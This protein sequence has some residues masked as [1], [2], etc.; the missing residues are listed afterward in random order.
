MTA[1]DGD[2]VFSTDGA[3]HG[4]C[5][6]CGRSPCACPPVVPV[7]PAETVLR[8]RLEA[9]GRKG[10]AVTVL[11]DLPH[12]PDYFAGVLK[13][14]KTHCGTGGAAKGDRLELQGDQRDKAQAWLEQAGFTVRRS[15]G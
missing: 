15:G 11:H 1:D 14:L 12:N 2:L 6:L 7:H 8:L 9:K 10:K 5:A 4:K 3:H 13:A